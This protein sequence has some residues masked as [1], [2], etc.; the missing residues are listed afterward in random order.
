MDR[1]SLIASTVRNL[2]RYRAEPTDR[3]ISAALPH[4]ED[5][6]IFI[7]TLTYRQWLAL[8]HAIRRAYV[9]QRAIDE[10]AARRKAHLDSGSASE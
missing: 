1:E 5:A 10:S 4:N 8:R 6:C 7:T 2:L 9:R 3:G